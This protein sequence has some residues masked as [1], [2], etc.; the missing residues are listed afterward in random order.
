MTTLGFDRDEAPETPWIAHVSKN[1]LEKAAFAHRLRDVVRTRR[2]QEL[3]EF[4]AHALTREPRE[5]IARMDCRGQAFGVEATCCEAGR[6]AKEPQN[7]QIILA[8]PRVSFADEA[9]SSRAEILEA[10]NVIVNRP[11]GAERERIDG[12]IA[13]PGVGDEVASKR[14]LGPPPIGLDVLTQCRRFER[15]PVDD[16]RHRSMRDASQSHLE[17]R[18][19]RAADDDVGRGGGCEVEIDRWFAEREI[20]HR[21]ADEPG[22]LALSVEDFERSGERSLFEERLILELSVC[23]TRNG[24]H[25]KRPGTSTPFSTCAGT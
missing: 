16:Y 3:Q 23:K 1:G 14:D 2:S 22:L 18:L 9:Y 20:P 13:P 7:A 19:S 25:S 10:A 6:E 5:S 21:A 24:G 15:A 12:E 4:G 17:S 11:V 8:N